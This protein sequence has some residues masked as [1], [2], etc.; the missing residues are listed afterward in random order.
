MK[1][2]KRREA[3]FS[4]ATQGVYLA[5]FVYYILSDL[6]KIFTEIIVVVPGSLA[7]CER[8]KLLEHSCR[9][10]ENVTGYDVDRWREAIKE[11]I[12]SGEIAELE[13]LTIL[14]DSFYGPF[15][16][17][18]KVFSYM[19][20][21]RV[22]FWGL[23]V[24]GAMPLELFQK[25]NISH[26]IQTYFVNFGERLIHSK[27]FATFWNALP[28]FHSYEETEEG[29]EYVLTDYFE[30]LHYTWAVYS[31]TRGW[32]NPNADRFV[33]FML[34]VPYDMAVKKNLPI[35]SRYAFHLDLKVTQNYHYGNQI[36]DLLEY[37]KTTQYPIKHIMRDL[38]YQQ[39]IYELV[40]KLNMNYIFE[41]KYCSLAIWKRNIAIFIY[42]Y[43]M[44][45]IEENVREFRKISGFID[46]YFFTDSNEKEELIKKALRKYHVRCRT[47]IIKVDARGREWAALLVD[48][49]KYVF[50]Y[51]YFGFLHD[52]KA[53][54]FEYPT[55]GEAFRELLWKN[56]IG[57]QQ[58]INEVIDI[59]EKNEYIGLMVPP[60]VKHGTYFR[61]YSD[62]WTVC[63]KTTVELARRLGIE[64]RYI[65]SSYTPI[66]IGSMF[67][68][69]TDALKVLFSYDFQREDFSTEPMPVDGTLS[70]AL[71]R[72]IP[73]I[74]QN[75]GYFTAV[76][77][78]KKFAEVDW[79]VCSDMVRNMISCSWC[80]ND[81]APMS[82]EEYITGFEVKE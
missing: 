39:N 32:E 26:F 50:Q 80:G 43:Y 30:R 13:E 2:H 17:F 37:I 7:E 63:Y 36:P 28:V 56:M 31:D 65:D 57:S 42:L 40:T 75:Q 25:N 4:I 8:K 54:D 10:K 49:K 76:I 53:H 11:L 33:S 22:D 81:I 38:I 51:K 5:D 18:E 15:Y 77:M 58:Y 74:A 14:N 82:Y 60:V 55:V 23:T 20:L 45:Q 12:K 62:F 79:N 9:I 16:S 72:I 35:A 61:Y 68:A 3:I 70:H 44:N 21:K 64:E 24:H 52:K 73:Y 59:F 47:K 27:D 29:F 6:E 46:L 19:E 66:S 41:G 34:L 1:V 67:W 69:R 71:E 48:A 78:T